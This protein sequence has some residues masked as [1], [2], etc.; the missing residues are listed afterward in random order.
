MACLTRNSAI[1]SFSL[2]LADFTL[3]FVDADDL[4]ERWDL[5]SEDAEAR[6]SSCMRF[7]CIRKDLIL[8]VKD[9]DI[10]I[11]TFGFLIQVRFVFN[12]E[13]MFFVGGGIMTHFIKLV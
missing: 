1:F 9:G 6:S 11:V 5:L 13:T 12:S 7:D 2:V 3:A 8:K 10:V 4:D